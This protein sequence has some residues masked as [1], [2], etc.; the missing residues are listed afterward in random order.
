MDGVLLADVAVLEVEEVT[1]V[2]E[3]DDESVVEVDVAEVVVRESEVDV[4]LV[5]NDEVVGVVV[6]DVVESEVEEE[7]DEGQ[8]LSPATL[9][10]FNATVLHPLL[11]TEPICR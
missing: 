10:A 1:S 2:L 3:V 6:V 9:I 8:P 11:R 4:V 7:V 5:L